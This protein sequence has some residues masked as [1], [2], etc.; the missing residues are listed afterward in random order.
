MAQ[1][2][3]IPHIP[4]VNAKHPNPCVS[5]VFEELTDF[6]T[7]RC[8]VVLNSEQPE[9]VLVEW[10]TFQN[11]ELGAFGVE[12]PVIDNCRRS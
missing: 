10:K 9:A 11:G 7:Y 3:A 4:V 8:A 12:A 2:L 6:L 1:Q 5:P